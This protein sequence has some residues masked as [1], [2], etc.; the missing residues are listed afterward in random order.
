M[1]EFATSMIADADVPTEQPVEAA[2]VPELMQS[3]L[4]EPY[5]IAT[6]VID[7]V[8]DK[9]KELQSSDQLT[10]T[11]PA[12]DQPELAVEI[13]EA[14]Q[15]ELDIIDQIKSESIDLENL[16]KSEDKVVESAELASELPAAKLTHAPGNSG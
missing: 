7:L 15:A 11:A 2:A 6:A 10:K 1:L 3:S 16:R 12:A 8:N 4:P 14:K 5:Q 13:E 9:V